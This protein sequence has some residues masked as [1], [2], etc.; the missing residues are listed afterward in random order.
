MGNTLLGILT[1]LS[2]TSF[3]SYGVVTDLKKPLPI[4]FPDEKREAFI[5]QKLNF[6]EVNLEDMKIKLYKDGNLKNEFPIKTKGDP[7][8]WGGS[9]VGLYQIL[10]GN[11]ISYSVASEVYMPYALHYYGKYYIHGEPYYFGGGKLIS[12][13]SGGCLR[14]ANKNAKSV[15]ELAEV[16]MPVLV[17]DKNKDDYLYPE[18]ELSDLS[19]VSAESYLAADL[20]SGFVFV[21]KKSNKKLSIASLTKLMTAVVVAEN[22]NLEKTIQVTE[23]MLEAYG[24]TKGL[25]KGKRFSVTDF[26]YPLLIESSNDAAEALSYFLGKERTIKLMN[27]KA[28]SIF[29]ENTEFA[30]PSGYDPKNISTARDLFYLARYILNNRP[31][32][33]EI[34]KGNRVR[35]FGNVSFDINE[36]WNKNVFIRDPT[37]TGGKTGYIKNSKGTAIFLFRLTTKDNQERNIVIIILG[38]E[39]VELDTQR[40]YIWLHKN[41]FKMQ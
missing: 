9:A 23:S 13:V 2:A 41:Y 40:I 12:S 10:G 25:E 16:G 7:K 37:F 24:S 6:L 28:G 19:N 30:D 31:P 39:S 29:M 1:F 17:I 38:S 35:S 4:E 5:S 22:V 8:H 3:L 14:L 34:T 15:Y 27:N 21:D 33:L 26:F 18:K 32:I 20:D 11:V 36:L